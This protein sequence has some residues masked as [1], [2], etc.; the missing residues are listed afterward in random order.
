[1]RTA[2]IAVLSSL[3]STIALTAPSVARA[4]DEEPLPAG[5]HR[6]SLRASI[7]EVSQ[8]RFLHG[9]RL[10]YLYV[11]NIHTPANG[12]DPNSETLSQKYGIRS[13]HQ[14]L[15]GYEFTWRMIG[16]EWLNVLLVANGMV[17]GLEQ[18]KVFPSANMLIGF[19]FAE[20]FQLGVGVNVVPVSDKP[21]HMLVAAGWTPR[22][23]DF[24]T[25]VHAFFIPDVD[26][27]HRTGVTI[28]VNW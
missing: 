13:P 16:H 22:I 28:G 2:P 12:A 3:I 25:P 26:G 21:G 14:F 23:G 15:I 1:M 5:D 6:E 17:A 18:S 4:D 20:S 10:G 7:D 9:F 24:Y 27:Q 8:Q 11:M 19:E